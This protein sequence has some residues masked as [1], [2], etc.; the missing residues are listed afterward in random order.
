MEIK[1]PFSKKRNKLKSGVY[2]G[3]VPYYPPLDIYQKI[4]EDANNPSPKGPRNGRPVKEPPI[5]SPEVPPIEAPSGEPSYRPNKPGRYA[6]Y[7]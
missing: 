2:A 3:G 1:K 6:Y 7:V 5:S 4:S